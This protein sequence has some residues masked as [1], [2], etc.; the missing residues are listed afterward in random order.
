MKLRVYNPSKT[1]QVTV[2]I[3]RFCNRV[4]LNVRSP[5]ITSISLKNRVL[6]TSRHV[7]QIPRHRVPKQQARAPHNNRLY[8]IS[9]GFPRNSVNSLSLELGN[10]PR[11][12]TATL[13]KDRHM[14]LFLHQYL[15]SITVT[16]RILP[17]GLSRLLNINYELQSR[18][19]H[20][21]PLIMLSHQLS[22][23]TRLR[24]VLNTFLISVFH[25]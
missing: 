23:L 7:L 16:R 9:T 17:R 6:R 21:P 13:R 8:L 24:H 1:S 19:S 22:S 14:R 20:T 10:R 12:H 15:R 2:A 25:L 11:D 18:N 5:R 3:I 4:S